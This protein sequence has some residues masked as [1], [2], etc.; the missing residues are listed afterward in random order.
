MKLNTTFPLKILTFDCN[1]AS[2]SHK[3]ATLDLLCT[4][5]LTEATCMNLFLLNQN[6]V[7]V[8]SRLEVRDSMN[9][10]LI[11]N[12]YRISNGAFHDI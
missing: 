11:M 10:L 1:D 3:V 9:T 7:I 8:M 12:A 4:A 2:Y 6:V 5:H